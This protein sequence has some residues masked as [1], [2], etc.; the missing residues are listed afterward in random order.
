MFSYV[1]MKVLE[2]RPRSYDQRMNAASRGR[3]RAI[4]GQVVDAVPPGAHVLEVGCGTGELASMLI[5]AGHTVEGFDRSPS[6]VEVAR[7]RIDSEGL[8][9]RFSVRQMGVEGMDGFADGAYGAVVATLVFSEL[10]ADERRYVLRHAFRVLEAGGRLVIADE[11]VPRGTGQRLLHALFRV[12]A[13][14]AVYLAFRRSTHPVADLA[15]EVRAAGFCVLSEE[16]SHGDAFALLV[17]ERS[18][19]AA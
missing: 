10:S 14:A 7:E 2:T 5:A 17:A 13:V 16:R 19:E 8:E 11:V 1:F 4:K 18:A 3:V 15:G 6:M 9:G 12:P